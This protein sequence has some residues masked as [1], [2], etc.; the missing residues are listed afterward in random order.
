VAGI[1]I[2][3]GIFTN[4]SQ[5]HLDFHHTMEEYAAA[6]ALLFSQCERAAA[7]AD[8]GWTTSSCKTHPS[9]FTPSP[10]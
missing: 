9:R 3:A 7:N 10:P 5:D 8:D 1:R 4:L 6:K 2:A